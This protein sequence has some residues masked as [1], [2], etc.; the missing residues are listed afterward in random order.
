MKGRGATTR[1]RPHYFWFSVPGGNNLNNIKII[2]KNRLKY[3]S[4]DNYTGCI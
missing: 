4:N 3:K 2:S 1:L